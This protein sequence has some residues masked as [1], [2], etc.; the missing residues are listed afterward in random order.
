MINVEVISHPFLARFRRFDSIKI[1]LRGFSPADLRFELVGKNSDSEGWSLKQIELAFI[2][3][4]HKNCEQILVENHKKTSNSNLW[5]DFSLT[6]SSHMTRSDIRMLICP[7]G[8]KHKKHSNRD[9]AFVFA[10]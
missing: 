5:A 9:F 4:W 2:M 3:N 6:Y 10:N 8:G 1:S 7:R